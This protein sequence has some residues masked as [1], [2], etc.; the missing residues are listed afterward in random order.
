[1]DEDYIHRERIEEFDTIQEAN[2]YISGLEVKAFHDP[3]QFA[4]ARS[5]RDNAKVIQ[6]EFS[7]V[8]VLGAEEL[9]VKGNNVWATAANAT[10]ASSYGPDWKTLALMDRCVWDDIN[11]KLFPETTRLLKE[12]E[13]PC[14]EA[15]YARMTPRSSIKPHSDYCNFALT[16]HLGLD[17]PEG[18]CW[19]EVGNQR[20]EWRNGEMLLFDTSLLHRAANE[21]DRTR[22]ILM[23]RVFHPGLA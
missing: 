3:Y 4:W 10:S 9:E 16:A 23:L 12:L 19:I 20:R 17:V 15:F 21:A 6:D 8:A 1:M 18:Q 14:L 22:Y 2:S 5:L 11:T 7:R 13:V